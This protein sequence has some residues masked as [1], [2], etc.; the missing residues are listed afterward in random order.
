MR[1]TCLS[2]LLQ[3]I[4]LSA[5]PQEFYASYNSLKTLDGSMIPVSEIL[6]SPKGTILVFWKVNNHKCY[7]NLENLQESWNEMAR[8]SGVKLVAVCVDN[9]GNWTR[10]KPLISGKDWDFDVY[11]DQNSSL[12]RALEITTL[13]YTI[14]LDGNVQIKCR[15]PGYCSGDEKLLCRQIMHCLEKDGTLAKFE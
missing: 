11:I 12:K 15:Y 1:T 6:T 4:F 5:Y 13:P 9:S 14:L 3:I 8:A 10:I 2:L 7:E